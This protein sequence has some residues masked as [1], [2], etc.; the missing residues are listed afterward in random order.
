MASTIGFIISLIVTLGYFYNENLIHNLT[1]LFVS[2]RWNTSDGQVQNSLLSVRSPKDC[3]GG[4][5]C[6]TQPSGYEDP[7]ISFENSHLNYLFSECEQFQ[8]LMPLQSRL[9]TPF[10]AVFM[11]SC[12]LHLLAT[13]S[14]FMDKIVQL[15]LAARSW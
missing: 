10:K 11:S 6:G 14:C 7:Q 9:I 8:L 13:S 4:Q 3:Y 5:I 2:V 12:L 1:S 15:Y